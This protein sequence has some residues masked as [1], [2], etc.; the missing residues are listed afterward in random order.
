MCR[1]SMERRFFYATGLFAVERIHQ[2]Q[3]RN[4]RLVRTSRSLRRLRAHRGREIKPF[5]RLTFALFADAPRINSGKMADLVSLGRKSFAVSLE[6]RVASRSYESMG[7]PVPGRCRS[8]GSTAGNR[9]GRPL[10]TGPGP[11]ISDREAARAN[12]CPFHAVGIFAA[13]QVRRI[14]AVEPQC[15]RKLLNELLRLLVFERMREAARQEQEGNS[16]RKDELE[17]RLRE[18]FGG[19]SVQARDELSLQLTA[20]RQIMSDADRQ[21][22]ELRLR[23]EEA[24]C[25]HDWTLGPPGGQAA[26]TGPAY[27]PAAG[28]RP[29]PGRT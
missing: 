28:N 26:R 11:S 10:A 5:R 17:R 22:P 3:G 29:G 27:R 21:L 15:C 16:A 9:H 18:D 19:I 20:Q 8:A 23:L 2:F 13:G 25:N 1:Y 24:R 6:F 4:H 14:A 12:L 7:T